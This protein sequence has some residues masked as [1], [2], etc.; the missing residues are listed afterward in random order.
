MHEKGSRDVVCPRIGHH[1]R[2]GESMLQEAAL[3]GSLAEALSRLVVQSCHRESHNQLSA[4]CTFLAIRGLHV[5][6]IGLC[7]KFLA[8]RWPSKPA[9][10][11]VVAEVG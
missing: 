9:P 8:S 7:N 6:V 10:P 4:V 11:H 5:L 1:G 2:C 3:V